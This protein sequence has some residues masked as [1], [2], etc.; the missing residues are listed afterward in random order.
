MIYP[1][2][3]SCRVWNDIDQMDEMRQGCTFANTW[4]EAMKNVE[5]YYGDDLINCELTMLED[6]PILELSEDA[7]KESLT[8]I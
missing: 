4:N 7:A 8:K 5:S 6:S 2:I 1:F 3:Y